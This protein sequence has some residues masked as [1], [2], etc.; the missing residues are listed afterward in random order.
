M[1]FLK[2]L[3]SIGPALGR[4]GLIIKVVAQLQQ[5][6]KPPPHCNHW[7]CHLTALYA[8]IIILT[9]SVDCLLLDPRVSTSIENYAQS[10]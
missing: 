5:G 2:A 7:F 10:V 4:L 1:S 3:S 6:L 9:I 8:S